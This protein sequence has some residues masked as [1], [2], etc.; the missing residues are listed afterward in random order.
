MDSAQMSSSTGS[1]AENPD[2]LCKICGDKAIGFNFQVVSCDSCRSFFRRCGNE[3]KLPTCPFDGSCKI[4]KASRKFCRACR[5]K[6]CY[7]EG[8]RHDSS[9]APDLIAQPKSPK[10]QKLKRPR[11]KCVCKCQCGFYPPET[12]LVSAQQNL[13]NINYRNPCSSSTIQTFSPR[14]GS[15]P[16][17]KYPYRVLSSEDQSLLS[18]LLSANEV[19]KA[20]MELTLKELDTSNDLSLRTVVRISDLAMR[21]IIAM[22]KLLSGFQK[23]YQADQIALLKGGLSELL[24]LRG[25]MCF[26][27][28]KGSWAHSIFAGDRPISLQVDIL[29]KTPE[30]QHYEIHR[31]FLHMFDERWR[32][33]ENVMLIL[34]AIVLF[35]ADRPR[36]QDHL[37]VRQTQ[38]LYIDLLERYLH[39]ECRPSEANDAYQTLMQQLLKLREVNRS[40]QL[41]Y[42][43][44]NPDDL[45]PLL[46]ELFASS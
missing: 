20:P 39:T 11:T 31:N 19:L 28:T 9:K 27:A 34:N 41:V 7:D 32:Q 22:A 25:L 29:K 14:L 24:I 1:Q 13:L 8:M 35:S 2:D 15:P 26:D 43:R 33:N 4:T 40:L 18:E 12:E 5:L 44:L 42:N 37:A 3:N 38:Q 16:E 45:E 21:R 30:E 17:Q 10:P 23:M 36:I 6:K 46:K